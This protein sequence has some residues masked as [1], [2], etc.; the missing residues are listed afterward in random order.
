MGLQGMVPS[1]SVVQANYTI[2]D[3][4]EPG[5]STLGDFEGPDKI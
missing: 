2:I 5:N 1:V 3:G 4:G